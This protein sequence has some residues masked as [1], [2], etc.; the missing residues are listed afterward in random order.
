MAAMTAV[1]GLVFNVLAAR[2]WGRSLLLK[3][4][5]RFTLGAFSDAGPSEETLKATR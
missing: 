4:P 5:E 2:S 1:M 3:H